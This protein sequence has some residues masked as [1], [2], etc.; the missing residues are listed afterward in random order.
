MIALLTIILFPPV[1]LFWFLIHPFVRLWPLAGLVV[2]YTVTLALPVAT[3]ATTYLFRDRVLAVVKLLL[4][5]G[6]GWGTFKAA[7][8]MRPTT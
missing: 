6:L 8:R 1:L 3:G 7:K 5:A 2:T 4:L